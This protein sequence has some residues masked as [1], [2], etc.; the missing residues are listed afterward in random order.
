MSTNKTKVFEVQY[1]GIVDTGI[2]GDS[3]RLV[4][5]GIVNTGGWKDAELIKRPSSIVTIPKTCQG[6]KA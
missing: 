2:P 6:L 5:S 3:P 4:A 1:V